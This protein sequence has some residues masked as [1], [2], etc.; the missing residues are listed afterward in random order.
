MTTILEQQNWEGQV[1]FRHWKIDCTG[2]N[3]FVLY[4]SA[5]HKKVYREVKNYKSVHEGAID[6]TQVLTLFMKGRHIAGVISMEAAFR[7]WVDQM[8]KTVP[9]PMDTV[10]HEVGCSLNH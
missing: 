1:G 6:A 8:L 2:H 7:A 9:I 3:T 4:H 5:T 10:S